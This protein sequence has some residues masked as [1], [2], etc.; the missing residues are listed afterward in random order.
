[1]RVLIL[2]L[3]SACLLLHGT[4][5]VSVSLRN[6]WTLKNSDRDIEIPHITIPSGIYSDLEAAHV[7]ESILFSD[8]DVKLREF[9]YLDW[10]YSLNFNM[11]SDDLDHNTI[12]LVFHGLDTI[13]EIFLNNESL[14]STDN[15]F[16]RYR[17]DVKNRLVQVCMQF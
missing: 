2:L 14:G 1:M 8:N 15:M 12:L 13:S 6:D 4:E 5:A 10:S 16:I 9:S 11:T 17:Y 3:I 7:T